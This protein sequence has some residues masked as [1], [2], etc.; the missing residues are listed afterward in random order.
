MS[1][2]MNVSPVDGLSGDNLPGLDP[3][4]F[5]RKEGVLMC[6]QVD[7]REIAQQAGTPTYVY[8]MAAIKAAIARYKEA[9]ADL[10]VT[11]CYA[12]KANSNQAIMRLMAS[13][14]LGA[15]VVSGGEYQRARQAGIPGDKITFAGVGKTRA[16]MEAAL[17]DGV[18]QFNIESLPELERLSQIAGNMGK[19]APVAL[20][21]NPDVDAKTHAKITTGTKENKFGV[22]I[23]LAPE[24]YEKAQQMPHIN[25][26]GVDM[27]IGSQ[28]MDIAPYDLA[29]QRMA[30]LVTALREKD[31][32]LS[33]LDLGGGVG[34]AYEGQTG[35]DL[36]EYAAIV[37]KNLQSLGMKIILEPGRSLVGMAGILLSE[38]IYEKQGHYKRHIILDAGMN[39]LIRPALYDAS[40]Q[41]VCITA[42]QDDPHS[43][44]DIVG[45]ICESSDTFLKNYPMPMMQA[46]ELVGLTAAGAY[47][48]VMTSSYNTRPEAAEILV[49]GEK[50]AVI[51]ERPQIE[52]LIDRDTVP[53]W[54]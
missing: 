42:R 53:N 22:D 9:F 24:F 26:I 30:D 34:I 6:E 44:A 36:T 52:E 16:E 32:H 11:I 17:R 46:G 51:R 43:L 21:I 25:P 45:P 41:L 49:N 50:W 15:D 13:E 1:D 29:Y 40:H 35:P 39:D 20:R 23:D 27:H 18:C 37:R 12:T 4:G 31:I 2:Q 48:A 5:H 47:A 19:T 54:V 33:Q 38:V 8:S 10:P 3:A 28:L 7:L 14:G